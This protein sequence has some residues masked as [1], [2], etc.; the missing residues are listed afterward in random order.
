M[1][2][3]Q[4][5]EE[6]KERLNKYLAACGI[7]SRREADRLIKTGKVTVDGEIASMGMQVTGQEE[8][9]VHGKKVFGKN[10]KV[11]LAYY[12]PVGV[13]VPD[14]C[15]LTYSPVCNKTMILP[16]SISQILPLTYC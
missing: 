15:F 2:E 10:D 8:I 12:K 1:R 9:A 3:T 5:M 4:S 7:C 13:T 14:V 6:K 11:V 16:L